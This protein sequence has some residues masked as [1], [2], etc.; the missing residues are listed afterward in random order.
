MKRDA[1]KILV[2]TGKAKKHIFQTDGT[3]NVKNE[4]CLE[5]LDKVGLDVGPEGAYYCGCGYAGQGEDESIVDFNIPATGQP[6]LWC[7]WVPTEDGTGIGWNGAEKFYNY[8][9]WLDYLIKHFLKP[10]GLVLNGEVEWQGE[11]QGDVGKIIVKDNVV[12]TKKA[13]ITWE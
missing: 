8:V 1:S 5:L 6:G 4:S 3:E 12:T 9:E 10:W 11:D 13:K 2:L 7:Q